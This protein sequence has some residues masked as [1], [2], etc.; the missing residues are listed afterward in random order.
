MGYCKN[1]RIEEIYASISTSMK[2]LRSYIL[3]SSRQLDISLQEHRFII[4]GLK[5]KEK[6]LVEKMSRSHVKKGK[7]KIIKKII[8]K[9]SKTNQGNAFKYG[10]QR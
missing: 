1:K 8:E 3:H 4:E 10:S 2:F 7:G 6:D 9:Q 5:N